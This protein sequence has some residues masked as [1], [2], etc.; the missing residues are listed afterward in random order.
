MFFVL[1][2]CR[3][4]GNPA[5]LQCFLR[6][7]REAGFQASP[8]FGSNKAPFHWYCRPFIDSSVDTQPVLTAALCPHLGLP[9]CSPTSPQ[10]PSSTGDRLFREQAEHFS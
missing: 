8:Q 4:A 2:R 1:T 6:V 3:T 9:D 10:S 5:S 7:T